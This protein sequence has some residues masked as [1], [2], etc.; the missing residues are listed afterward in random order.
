MRRFVGDL[1]TNNEGVLTGIKAAV[2][3]AGNEASLIP[4]RDV[5]VA[6]VHRTSAAELSQR[7]QSEGRGRPPFRITTA[8]FEG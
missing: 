5:V 7:D 4:A 8:I 3:S 1:G 2:D 6:A